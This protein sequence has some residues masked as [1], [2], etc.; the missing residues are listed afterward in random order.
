M[1]DREKTYWYCLYESY[2]LPEM[3][4]TLTIGEGL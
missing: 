1:W 2:I 3:R 4:R